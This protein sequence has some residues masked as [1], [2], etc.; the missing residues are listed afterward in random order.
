MI[1]PTTLLLLAALAPCWG[2]AQPAAD[3]AL[4]RLTVTITD[5]QVGWLKRQAKVRGMSVSA[6]I[7]VLVDTERARLESITRNT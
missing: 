1:R 5:D 3:D 6:L 7:R 4:A 2:G